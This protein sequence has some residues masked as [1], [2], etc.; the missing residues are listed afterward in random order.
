[1]IFFGQNAEDVVLARLFD[2]HEGFYVDLGAGHPIY[3]SVTKH[4]YDRGWRGLDVEPLPE[5][6]ALLQADR[7][8]DIVVSAA[9]TDRS[10]TATLHVAP[11]ECRG[12]STILDELALPGSEETIEVPTVRLGELLAEHGVSHID[13]LKIDVEGAEEVIV[14]DTDWTTVRPRVLVI[15]ATR[16]GD[17][18][19]THGSW[20]PTLNAAGYVCTLFDG[21]NRFYAFADD[22][23][24]IAALS[25]P[26][27]PLDAAQP[28]VWIEQVRTL[29]ELLD[30][31]TTARVRLERDVT[32]LD[33]ARNIAEARVEGI[34]RELAA[35]AESARELAQLAN[36]GGQILSGRT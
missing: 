31:Q 35:A 20:E 3:D 5:E 10:G 25:V 19:P 7:P 33:K 11:P 12:R 26:A 13:F 17:P 8:D 14:R 32:D 36:P 30:A 16:P 23:E 24:A 22:P 1:V 9:V 27:N 2:G 15:E 28:W 29:E 34:G 6:A 4:F 21:L 18:T